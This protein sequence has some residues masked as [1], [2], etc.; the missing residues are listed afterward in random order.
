MIR[1][2]VIK[3]HYFLFQSMVALLLMGAALSVSAEVNVITQKGVAT[4]LSKEQIKKLFFGEKI[5]LFDGSH[6]E[7]RELPEGHPVRAEFY[8]KVLGKTERQM[9]SYWAKWVFSGK[10]MPPQVVSSE[11]DVVRWVSSGNKSG[12]IGYVGKISLPDNVEVLVKE[13]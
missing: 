8:K 6:I 3:L 5:K 1:K 12:R 11:S 7:I 10:G 2:A 13:E 4:E 9:K